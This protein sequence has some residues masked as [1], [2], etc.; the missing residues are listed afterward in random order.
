MNPL[1]ALP[2][3]AHRR[4]GGC[5]I[6]V[7]TPPTDV[8]VAPLYPALREVTAEIARGKAGQATIVLSTRRDERGRWDVEDSGVFLDWTPVRICAA[9]G[10]T[11]RE[12]I[13]QGVVREIKVAH[14]PNLG[15]STVTVTVQ[16]LSLVAD[17]EH[18]RQVWGQE[19]VRSADAQIVPTVLG[20][21]GLLPH[22]DSDL[23]VAAITVNQDG[24]DAAL[25][26]ARA[27]ANGYELLYE[28]RQVYFGPIARRM[29]GPPVQKPII[30]G[31]G[32]DTTCLSVDIEVDGRRPDVV[33]VEFAA[34]K[35]TGA[36]AET[37]RVTPSLPRLGLE[38]VTSSGPG[39]HSLRMAGS[40]DDR[41]EL[42]RRAQAKVDE[43]S[44]KIKA[45]GEL[46]GTAYGHVL[47]VGHTV[48]LDG[49]G[50]RFSGSHL[51]DSVTH[52][53]TPEGYTQKFTLLR[54]AYTD[55]GAVGAVSA[56][57]GVLG[58]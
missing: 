29:T 17:R 3:L 20:R 37:V 21:N 23:P 15:E 55:D 56:L 40:G 57:A 42:R 28:G 30:V 11:A 41:D 43:L 38:P 45:T 18:R 14:P 33:L 31:S 1:A 51:V 22:P 5:V 54:N 16:D 34:A 32:P 53:F 24:T 35:A 12:E 9:F 58:G 19:P 27:E 8:A 46:D 48:R 39:E 52:R 26:R 25:L 50:P 47:R 4:P 49:V 36:T 10:L 44:L 13:L 7:G 6:E 2:A